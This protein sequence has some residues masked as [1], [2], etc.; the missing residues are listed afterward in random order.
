MATRSA[1]TVSQCLDDLP[2]E[3]RPVVSAVPVDDFIARYEA[4]RRH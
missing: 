4:C 3:R 2:A 1:T